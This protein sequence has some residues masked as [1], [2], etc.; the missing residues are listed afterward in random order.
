MS[1]KTTAHTFHI[2][3]MGL[4][5]TVDSP[6]KVAQYG[7]SSVVSIVDD[8]LIEKM[9]EF[10]SQKFKLPFQSFP[11]K[12]LDSRARRITSY[13]NNMDI[14]VK[15][16]FQEFKEALVEKKEVL[17]DYLEMLPDFSE[18]KTNLIHLIEENASKDTLQKWIQ[19][20]LTPGEIDVN[21]MTKL[22]GQNYHKKELLGTEHNDAHAALRGFAKSN[23]SSSIVLSAGMNPRLYS[24]FEEF[25]DFYPNE[26][27][28]LKKKIILKVSDYRSA[29]IQGQFFAKK[30]LWVS[31]YR[32][33]SGLNCG[34]HAFATEGLLLGPILNAFQTNKESL[35]ESTYQTYAK[36]LEAKG[37]H[38]PEKPLDV[39]IT[40]QGG[41]GTSEE[42][43]FLLDTYN[44]SSVGWGSP[45]LLVPEATTV[46]NDTLNVLAKAK[47][48][49]LY[50]SN[51]SPLGVPFN[52][53]KGVSNDT[54]KLWKL[55]NDK[56]GSACPKKFLALNQDSNGKSICT[57]SQKYQ[58][59]EIE[60]L[61]EEEL[62]SEA[63][64]SKFDKITEKSCLC[65]GLANAGL[66]EKN[67]DSKDT[68][69][70]VLVC[71]GPN[72]AY[73]D[74]EVSLKNMVQHIY[75]KTNVMDAKERPHMFVKELDMYVKYFNE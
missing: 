46:D 29:T 43:Q 15:N 50:L 32:I 38:V 2:P 68:K 34:G 25:E 9:N 19:E 45:F 51:I 6:I 47:E 39:N 48:E 20:N 8:V 70:G 49:D 56:I 57:A 67:I 52:S 66:I 10:Y 21:I 35:V 53:V 24:Y 12:E 11:T 42:H 30:G 5:F 14:I 17:N 18:I 4:A 31:E 33:E 75:G 65:I 22:D 61:K 40:V 7:I 60:K 73:F 36:A 1:I 74:K 41:V 23:L 3:V 71:P 13:L 59:A 27:D 58:S 28:E 26:N 16:K 54:Y 69:A 62:S 55:E 37:K 63:Y 44:V 64:Q 72:I